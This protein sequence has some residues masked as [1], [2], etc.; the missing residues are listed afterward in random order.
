[1][2]T[3]D[4]R[5]LL[6]A[7]GLAG[8]GLG[9]Q[10]VCGQPAAGSR[11]NI[12][13]IQTD[14]L[15]VKALSC[16]GGAVPTPNIDR[17]ACEGALFRHAYAARPTSSPCRASIVTGL[18]THQHGVVSNV[19]PQKQEGL[20]PEDITTDKILFENGYDTHHYGKWHIGGEGRFPYFPDMYG[21]TD[22]VRE[23]RARAAGRQRNDTGE[24]MFFKGLPFPVELAE[25][26]ASRQSWF[27]EH[28]GRK[29][30][31]E[32]VAKIGR[33]RDEPGSWVDAMVCD[34]TI[35]T[36]NALKGSGRP[37]MITTSFIYPHDPN[38]VSSPY[39]EMFD[40]GT[41]ETAGT[42]KIEKIYE[43]DWSAQLARG[44]GEE[45]VKEFLRIYCAAVK[46]ID[47]QV[48]RLLAALEANG[49]LEHTV[50]VFTADHGDMMG[51][52]GMVWKTTSSFYQDV[53]QIPFIVYYPKAVK[54]GIYDVP[55]SVV[56]FMP[57]FLSAAGHPE[58]LPAGRPGID[59][60]PYLI[61]GSMEEFPRK[62]AVSERID[63]NAGGERAVKPDPSA[64]FMITDTR[65][66]YVVH[67]DGRQLLFDLE[68]D[69]METTNVIA[70]NPTRKRE[71]REALMN[72]LHETGWTGGYGFFSRLD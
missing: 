52:H 7:C 24:W 30:N 58:L 5:F 62:Y 31:F 3:P 14:Q 10:A 21:Y 34:K 42:D 68:C 66:K 71:L 43:K 17:L 60:M 33:L 6:A 67:P 44:W 55:V 1:M 19:A 40:P 56:D 20:T 8:Y 9:V 32:S 50:I 45:G 70:S 16:Y 61:N 26:I 25:P 54:P 41:L 11:P 15:S 28:W 13:F 72:W 51:N 29:A 65:W 2:K 47:D 63:N 22:Y 57:T 23:N 64:G 35:E 4:K 12:L 46:Y 37:F 48:G 18:Y 49:Q 39:Y 27:R 38:F 53:V 69:P 59:L 36:L